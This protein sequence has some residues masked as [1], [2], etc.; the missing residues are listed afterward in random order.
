[1]EATTRRGLAW[2]LAMQNGDGGWGAFDHNNDRRFL[3]QIPFAD[4]NAMIDPSTA[5]VTARVVECLGR[6]GWPATPPS[7]DR[8]RGTIPSARSDRRWFLVWALGSELRVWDKRR[9][10]SARN[11]CVERAGLLSACGRMAP[12]GAKF[13]WRIW[14]INRFLLRSR[15]K[16]HRRQHGVSDRM[17]PDWITRGR[18]AGGPGH[19]PRAVKHL[20]EQQRANG[21][22]AESEFYRHGVSVRLLPEISTLY[23]NYFPLYACSRDTAIMTRR[24]KSCSSRGL[25]SAAPGIRA[26]TGLGE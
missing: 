15:S 24:A 4:H 7:G 17:G 10:A 14:R 23:R 20:V 2:L 3:C 12:R 13:R 5:D 26:T 6:Y 22:W 19:R 11:G 8:A 9:A 21:S 18:R 16:G 1:M 25:R